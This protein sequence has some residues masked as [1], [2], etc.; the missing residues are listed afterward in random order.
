MQVTRVFTE[1]AAAYTKGY[2]FIINKGGTRSGKTFS[3]LQLQYMIMSLSKKKRIISTVSHSLPHLE[4]GAIRDFDNI[5]EGNGVSVDTVRTKRPYIYTINKGIHEF[6]GFD[7]PG[8]A[9]GSARDIL[10]INEANKM[11]WAIVHQL[12]QRT[13][14]CIFIDYNPA[15]EFW[16]DLE[17]I[18]TRK[19]AIVINSTFYDNIQNLT[20]GQIDDLKE[21]KRKAMFE[22]AKGKRGYWWNWWQVYGLGLPGQLEGVI[23]Q[24]WQE[25][26]KLPD[27]VELFRL[28]A[29]DWGGNDPTTLTEIN[30][31]G[32][33]NRLYVKEH[34]Y[35]PQYLNSKLIEYLLKHNPENSY[36]VCDSAR[37]DKI[38]ELQMAGINAVG[39]SKGEGS[40]IDGIDRMQ[41]FDIFVHKDSENAKY[42]FGHYM[43]A[44]D[45]STG[46]S[47]NVPEDA[48]NHIID[49]VR[50][51]L[52]FYKR[53]IKP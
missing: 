33:Y 37:K 31:D 3:A 18:S 26:D 25:Y 11:E 5:I 51:A 16:V 29:I 4:G 44:Q 38:F 46:K 20:A 50:Y 10:F 39:A 23:F 45:K 12:M 21:A 42:E 40:I 34:I 35:T 30:I 48:N 19:D 8:K 15:N 32:T 47:L 24:N 17:G 6:I 27:N 52:R 36:V 1:T 41:E 43:W 49:G 22:N 2:R 7:S 13:T 53:N 28:F 14:E 9:L